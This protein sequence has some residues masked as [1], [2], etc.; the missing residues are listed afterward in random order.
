MKRS[1][2]SCCAIWTFG[3]F[4]FTASL[5]WA[6]VDLG[7]LTISGG[8]E[9]GGLPRTFT[10]DKAKFEEYR[11]IPET[12]IVPQLQLIIGGKKEDYYLNFN[13]TEVGR[14]DQGYN[15][16][17]GR[18]GLVDLEFSWDQIPHIFSLDT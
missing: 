18:Y 4:F 2:V 3:T 7:D 1:K 16:R 13:A 15:L 10:G 17:V 6:Q 11:D 8:A 5:S 9:I 14:H 12:V